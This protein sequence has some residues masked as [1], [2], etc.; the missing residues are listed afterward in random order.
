LIDADR[1]IV[2]STESFRERYENADA[3]WQGSPELELVLTGQADTAV[4]NAGEVSVAIEAVTDTH[5]TRHVMLSLPSSEQSLPSGAPIAALREPLD[6]SRAMVWVKDLD[7][8]YVYVN[9]RFTSDLGTTE[10]RL[11]GQ[12]DDELPRRHTVDG[13][14]DRSAADKLQEPLQLEYAVPA[15]EGRPALVALRFVTRD[16]DGQ[17]VGV[18]GVAAPWGEAQLARED[19][20]R[21]MRIERWSRLDPADVRAELLE[22]WGVA[23]DDVATAPESEPV[24]TEPEAA[25]PEPEPMQPAPEAVQPE[26]EPPQPAPEP[27]QSEPEP[28]QP[29]PE[30]MQPEPEPAP[31]QHMLG[32]AEGEGLADSVQRLQQELEQARAEVDQARADAQAARADLELA[33][34]EREQAREEREQARAERE[35]A[36]TDADR[37]RALVVEARTATMLAQGEA[38]AARIQLAQAAL[39]FTRPSE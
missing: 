13:P 21:L 20:S 33:R 9:G 12:T 28:M 3:A 17:P 23:P 38:Q 10:E 36:R 31:A 34:S 30:L 6:E 29:E 26:H 22:E 15:F 8:R 19:A 27:A 16:P 24:H 32:E 14:R 37:A 2:R 4:L 5:G 1:R 39:A 25:Q 7:G 18:C 11:L 35:Q